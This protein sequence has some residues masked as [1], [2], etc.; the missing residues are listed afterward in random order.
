MCFTAAVI[1]IAIALLR[2]CSQAVG[3]SVVKGGY[4]CFSGKLGLIIIKDSL[5]SFK[6]FCSFDFI[7]K[8]HL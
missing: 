1:L 2:W 3:K 5:I 7:L 8:K 4:G 6:A